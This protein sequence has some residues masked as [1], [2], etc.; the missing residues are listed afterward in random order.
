MC[1]LNNPC[2]LATSSQG[3]LNQN[4]RNVCQT[5]RDRRRC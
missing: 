2:T 5:S 3:L 1:A 4:W